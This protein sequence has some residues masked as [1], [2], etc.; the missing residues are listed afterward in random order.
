MRGNYAT[1][2]IQRNATSESF[3]C[4]IEDQAFSP[5]Y[6]LDPFPPP[7]P[8]YVRKLDRRHIGRLRKERQLADG[9]GREG[10]GG[11]AK[12]CESEKACMV[13]DIL[14]NTLWC[15]LS[16]I[17]SPTP[18]LLLSSADTHMPHRATVLNTVSGRLSWTTTAMARKPG[19]R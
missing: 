18:I 10:G 5:L 11:G 3:E 1:G 15:T 2:N 7:P 14:F 8:S 19:S 16:H 9:G 6:D 4:F 12:S 13:L 17:L